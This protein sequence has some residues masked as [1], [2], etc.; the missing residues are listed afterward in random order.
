MP[1]RQANVLARMVVFTSGI[2]DTS[3]LLVSQALCLGKHGL[4][5]ISTLLGPE[6]SAVWRG[7]V[8]REVL[9]HGVVWCGC[10]GPP[11]ACVP[12]CGGV[13]VGGVVV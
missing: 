10:S 2:V 7:V 4:G 12:V 1:R 13:G 6:E 8:T 9:R 3:G 5:S 11:F